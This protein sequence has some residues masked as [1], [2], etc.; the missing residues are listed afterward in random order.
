MMFLVI[1]G[2][3]A[4]AMAI[5]SQG[6]LHTADTHIKVNRSLSASETGMRLMMYRLSNACESVLTRSGAVWD[7][8][9]G[10]YL[11]TLNSSDLASDTSGM[12]VDVLLG[13]S[14]AIWAEIT[15]NAADVETLRG[16][17]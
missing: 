14:D 17:A 16:S 13:K 3:L 8:A 1:F 4:A 6:N 11:T 7:P 10:T 2:S 15:S 9:A 12:P 5:V